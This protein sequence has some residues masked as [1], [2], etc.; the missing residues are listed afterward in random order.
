[1]RRPVF[2]RDLAIFLLLGAVYFVAGKFGLALA[3]IHAS[4]SAVWPPTGIALAA[5]LLLGYRVWPAILI[6]AFLVNLT[7]AGNLATSIGVGAGNALEAIAGAWLVNRYAGGLRAFDRPQD[8]FKFFLLAGLLSTALSPTIGVTSLAL[9]GFARWADFLPIWFTWW[10]GDVGGA[11]VVAP[12]LILWGVDHQVRW[13]RARMIEA[14][15]LLL[16]LVLVS[17]TVFNDLLGAALSRRSLTFL[18]IP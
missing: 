3:S 2:L 8:S 9:G 10:L 17:L 1:M 18:C 15:A 5:A 12:A 16:A 13:S 6:G 7:T 14:V 4:A 11:L